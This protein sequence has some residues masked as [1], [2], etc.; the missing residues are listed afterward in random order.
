ML[1]ERS[2]G[3]TEDSHGPLV[4]ASVSDDDDDNEK[5]PTMALWKDGPRQI[6]TSITVTR[7][8]NIGTPLP[9]LSLI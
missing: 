3:L 2:Q 4:I 9:A 1:S 5:A 7:V 6:Q 8:G